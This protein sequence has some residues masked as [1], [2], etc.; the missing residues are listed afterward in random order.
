MMI[1]R[2]YGKVKTKKQLEKIDKENRK[3]EEE[4]KL[5]EK[6]WMKTTIRFH[7]EYKKWLWFAWDLNQQTIGKGNGNSI[8]ACST[9]VEELRK[10][11][12][13]AAKNE[14]EVIL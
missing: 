5:R 12:V 1:M 10:L 9:Q 11:V 7:P 13:Y 8:R 6:I 14:M 2:E 4:N 3:A